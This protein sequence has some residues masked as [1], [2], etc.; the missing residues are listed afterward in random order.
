M[1]EKS[2]SPT[3]Y[4]SPAVVRPAA[5][6]PLALTYNDLPAEARSAIASPPPPVLRFALTRVNRQALERVPEVT[7]ELLRHVTVDDGWPREVLGD[8]RRQEWDSPRVLYFDVR[9]RTRCRAVLKALTAAAR[10][11]GEGIRGGRGPSHC[12]D[13]AR[14]ILSDHGFRFAPTDPYDIVHKP[15]LRTTD[16]IDYPSCR[17]LLGSGAE[18]EHTLEV[19]QSEFPASAVAEFEASGVFAEIDRMSV[20][21]TRKTND[22][23]IEGDNWME[24]VGEHTL[25]SGSR[26][27]V[28]FSL[29]ER[30]IESPAEPGVW[31]Q[32]L[33]GRGSIHWEVRP[34]SHEDPPSYPPI[35][36]GAMEVQYD[37]RSQV[38]RCRTASPITAKW[39]GEDGPGWVT[40]QVCECR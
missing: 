24:W 11:P 3:G 38:L 7:A 2:C 13:V 31:V 30:S 15:P 17:H 37:A 32:P 9:T 14:S 21:L 27:A 28:T 36:S 33:T 5:V 39:N 16:L 6:S 22:Y 35:A 18:P 8:A 20:D 29:D 4:V 12:G 1:A 19:D 25:P 23:Y 34:A 40:A 10:V 26:L